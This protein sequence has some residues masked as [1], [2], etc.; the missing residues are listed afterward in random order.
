MEKD[1]IQKAIYEM[2]SKLQKTT[3][4]MRIY[5]FVQYIYKREADG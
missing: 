5:K 2:V 4:L 3:S 1:V